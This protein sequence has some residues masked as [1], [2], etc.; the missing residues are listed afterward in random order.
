MW[1]S[2]HCLRSPDRPATQ[3]TSRVRLHAEPRPYAFRQVLR[4][5]P[6]HCRVDQ[7]SD[8]KS[9][10]CV[11]IPNRA[12]LAR[13]R[14]PAH[15]FEDRSWFASQLSFEHA[16]AIGCGVRISFIPPDSRGHLQQISNA[17]SVIGAASES[18][19]IL[20]YRVVNT[21][22]IAIANRNSDEGRTDRLTIDIDI[23][24]V[25]SLLPSS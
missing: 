13:A 6:F 17:D 1:R 3:A 12:R 23:Q 2:D 7:F 10:T 4:D 21:F 24:C 11:V 22:Y 15:Q 20:G 8:N 18:R 14:K 9:F 16:A 5:R 19:Q 25:L